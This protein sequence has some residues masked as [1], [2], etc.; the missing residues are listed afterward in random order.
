MC[1]YPIEITRNLP[2]KKS[3]ANIGGKNVIIT[4]MGACEIHI[5]ETK[6][7]TRLINR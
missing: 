5:V 3:Y 1:L 7:K 4:I 2:S 6:E